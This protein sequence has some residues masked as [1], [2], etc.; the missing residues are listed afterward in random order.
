V[1]TRPPPFEEALANRLRGATRVAV[2][3]IGD[4][5]LPTDRIGMVTAREVQALRLPRVV[6]HL[7]GTL[8]ESF[9]APIRRSRPDHVLLLDA[10]DMRTRPGT[11]A[12]LSSGAVRGSR[13]STHA[14]PLTVLISYLEG[15]MGVPVTLVGMQ[16]ELKVRTAALSPAEHAAVAQ[17]V[18][19]IQRLL[20]PRGARPPQKRRRAR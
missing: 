16:P 13:L 7:A 19:A 11:V 6:V 14:L 4:E 8:P 20:G 15:T 3:G 5:L 9:T 10:A 1:T 2:V 12:I 18:C 17:V